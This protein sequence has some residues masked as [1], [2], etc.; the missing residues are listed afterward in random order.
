MLTLQVYQDS[1][2]GK[3]LADYSNR[4]N[5]GGLRFSTNE[6]G[7]AALEAGLIVMPLTQAFEVYEWQGLP[8]VVVSDNATGVIWEGRLEDI[9]VVDGGI[10]LGAFGYQRALHDVPYTALWSWTGSAD[11]REVTNNDLSAFATSRYEIDNNNRLYVALRK[12]ETY[13]NQTNLGGLTYCVPNR[14]QRN[15]TNF[16]CSYDVDLPAN[17]EF[18]VRSMTDAFGSAAVENTLTATGSQ[19]TGTLSLT[20]TANERVVVEA[21]NNTGG[22]T[23]FAG[24]TS[25]DYIKLTSIRVKSTTAASVLAS[26]IAAAL[27]AFVNSINSD[28]LSSSAAFIEAT[29][30]DLQDEVYEDQYPADILN[31]LAL[32]HT[33]EW[34]VWEGQ[35]LHF[36]SKGSAGRTW[37]VDATRIANIQRSIENLY[38]SAYVTLQEAG[39]RTIRTANSGDP[40]SQSKYGVLRRGFTS[41]Q[42]TSAT[43]ANIHREA[44][45]A[46][47]KTLA[48]RANVEFERVYDALGA[49]Y[50]L[51][52]IRAGDTVT[53]RNLPPTLSTDIDR[54][55][56]FVVGETEYDALENRISV[57]PQDPIPTLVTLVARREEGIR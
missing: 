36:H 9:E 42:S 2:M 26:D 3:L 27:A 51:Y 38:N 43:E 44:F 23:T 28:Q 7:F 33:Y 40:N 47:R 32:L 54:I 5:D 22:S 12:G 25:E 53:I 1:T 50:P 34:A 30:T 24:N 8:H 19:Q 29:T 31:D 17:W 56:S 20:L 11:W 55:R 16:S 18:R 41:V 49:E 57:T 10:R 52:S 48:I 21:R 39:G 37:Y 4:L 35:R 15:I 46:D 45:L 6:H 13:F 14:G